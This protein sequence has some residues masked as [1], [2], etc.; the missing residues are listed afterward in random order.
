MTGKRLS[1]WVVPWLVFRVLVRPVRLVS[2][3]GFDLMRMF[4]FFG[5]GGFVSDIAPQERFFGPAPTSRDAI[6]R[7]ARANS[8][9]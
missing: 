6:T 9:I 8:L 7:W 1:I 5:R 4:L 3:L 2:E